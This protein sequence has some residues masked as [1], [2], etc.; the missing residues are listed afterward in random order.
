MSHSASQS[1][2]RTMNRECR[3]T[4]VQ[5]IGL[6]VGIGVIMALITA[7]LLFLQSECTEGTP[8]LPAIFPCFTAQ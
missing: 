6:V 5:L 2:N 7:S 3:T 1:S 8:L 4:A